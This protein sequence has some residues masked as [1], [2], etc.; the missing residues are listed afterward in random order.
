MNL[1]VEILKEHSK[2]QA[3]RI[4]SWIGTDKKR[5]KSLMD[6]FLRGEYR[7]TQ[8]SAWIVNLC[9]EAHPALLRPYLRRM[10]ARMQQPGVHDSVKRNV[11][12]ILQFIP[13]PDELMG[14]VTLVCFE[15]LASPKE[16]IAV[17]VFSMAVLAN[18]AQK[19]P[20]LK[21]ELRLTIE[22]QLEHGGMAFCSRARKVMKMID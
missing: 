21:N 7:T 11:I 6:L 4:A 18:I 20:G 13:I 8:R 15:Y 19:E 3:V 12:R 22:R 9:A 10:I 14:E 2:R 1:E 5:F 16:P 17:R